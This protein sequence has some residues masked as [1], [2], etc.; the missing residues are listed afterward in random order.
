MNTDF[1]AVFAGLIACA[2]I[3]PVAAAGSGPNKEKVLYSFCSNQN[4]TDGAF[5]R[6][7]LIEVNGTL[8]STTS[9]G[10][11]YDGGAGTVFTLDPKTG[12]EKVIYSFCSQLEGT[13]CLDGSVPGASLIDVNG[14]L[15]GTTEHGGTG[16]AG[17][18]FSIDP[19]TSA[20]TVHYNFSGADGAMPE[21]ELLNVNGVLYGTTF[22]GGTGCADGGC[23]TVFSLDPATDAE[24]V[25]HS[26]GSG[27]DGSGPIAGLVDVKG[28]L[29]GTARAGG[30]YGEGVIFSI[31]PKTGVE[32][33]LYSFCAQSGCADGADPETTMLYVR[34]VL[35]GTTDAGAANAN[36][37]NTGNIGCGVIFTFDPKT[38]AEAVAY[39]F[40]AASHCTD[41]QYP[42]GDLIDV[43]GTLYGTTYRGGQPAGCDDENGGCGTVFSFDPKTGMEKVLYSF[44]SGSSTDGLQ[45]ISGLLPVKDR[46]YG[47][48]LFGGGGFARDGVVFEL[49]R[50]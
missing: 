44:G 33:V 22:D 23:G 21:A 36:C 34:G 28:T 42:E 48:T 26:F 43:K 45:P 37:P 25:L 30:T 19:N 17:T 35:Y 4:C 49:N 2:L 13:D 40:C 9:L 38:G 3:Q 1:L 18:V 11:V 6:A 39:S 47:T 16:E 24:T 20:E 5:P 10:G 8:Y 7:R 46:L 32:N 41:G 15:Y 27:T 14:T 12:K 29:Y 50:R 31:D